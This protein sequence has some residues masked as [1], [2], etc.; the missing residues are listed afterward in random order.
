MKVTK[1]FPEFLGLIIALRILA[2]TC[3]ASASDTDTVEVR[4]AS[5]E[6]R[7]ADW[8]HN[9]KNKLA[10]DLYYIGV[11]GNNELVACVGYS[12]PARVG[13]SVT[14]FF[15]GITAKENKERGVKAAA[16]I[17]WE[18]ERWKGDVY[19]ARF[20]PL[21]GNVSSY[22]VLDAANFTYSASK[23]WEVGV[24]TG[25]FRQDGKWNPLVGPLIRL[26]D[27]FGYWGISVRTGSTTE[28]RVIRTITLI[29]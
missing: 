14:P 10:T 4:S 23:R 6:Y 19:Y 8:T 22:D 5:G 9:F 29:R 17:S 15:C 24:S 3:W 25:F 13:L 2:P 21:R 28:L 7:Y 27:K 26:H 16:A 1:V 18:K 12:F 20:H 11:P